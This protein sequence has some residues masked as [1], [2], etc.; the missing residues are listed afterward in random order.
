MDGG[1]DEGQGG[2]GGDGDAARDLV[3][4]EEGTVLG[5]TTGELVGDEGTVLDLDT[6][7]GREGGG[8]APDQLA[9]GQGQLTPVQG[10]LNE[11][12]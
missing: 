6:G 1:F 3:A 5:Q 4:L 7:Q 10:E 2:G 8:Q 9:L 11:P 12:F